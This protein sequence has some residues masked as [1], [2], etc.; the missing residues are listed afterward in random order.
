MDVAV[1]GCHPDYFVYQFGRLFF[2]HVSK[3]AYPK[4]LERDF[5]RVFQVEYF[6]KMYDDG[7]YIIMQ[8]RRS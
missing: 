5:G 1:M 8:R 6:E 2:E 7:E 4:K 3:I